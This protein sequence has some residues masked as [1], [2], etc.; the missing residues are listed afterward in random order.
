MSQQN[1]PRPHLGVTTAATPGTSGSEP[2]TPHTP[3]RSFSAM[4][5]LQMRMS[6]FHDNP[7]SSSNSPHVGNVSA[8]CLSHIA[9]TNAAM[10]E[11]DFELGKPIGMLEGKCSLIS[12][13]SDQGI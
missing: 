1:S 9:E 4:D 3:R 7:T 12:R 6:S 10:K 11:E 2:S 13:D 5:A 8:S